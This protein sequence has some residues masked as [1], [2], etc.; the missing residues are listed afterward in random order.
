MRTF[1]VLW[2]IVTFYTIIMAS[3]IELKDIGTDMGLTG[4]ELR[5]F[6]TEQQTQ[7]RNDRQLEREKLAQEHDARAQEHEAAQEVIKMKLQ[8]HLHNDKAQH[9]AEH[10]K[11]PLQLQT[12]QAKIQIQVQ[13]EQ[14]K[15][16]ERD[17]EIKLQLME[18]EAELQTAT[19]HTGNT[20]QHNQSRHG[21]VP[22]APRLPP[23]EDKDDMDAYLQRFERYAHA[24]KWKEEEWAMHLGA[25]LKGKALEVYSR[26]TPELALDYD[27]LKKALLKRFDLTEEGFRKRFETS[28][29][30]QGETFIQFAIRLGNYM[31]R[32]IEL[33]STEKS[34]EGIVDLFIRTQLLQ[35]CGRDLLLFLKERVPKS[36]DEMATLA[37][38]FCD[39]RGRDY[40][41]FSHRTDRRD[42]RNFTPS[43]KDRTDSSTTSSNK[44]SWN[45]N[46]SYK[47]PASQPAASRSYN[48]PQRPDKRCFL[49]NRTGHF[50]S[51][52]R[53]LQAAQKAAAVSLAE[54]ENGA[55]SVGFVD[56]DAEG[57]Q[58]SKRPGSRRRG[59]NSQGGNTGWAGACVAYTPTTP[60]ITTAGSQTFDTVLTSACH[61][62]KMSDGM[63]TSQG[64][65]GD[66]TVTV[67]RD[68]GCSGV[69]VRR[70]LVMDDQLLG[71]NQNCMLADGT[72]VPVP[73][74]EI[75]VNTT[76]YIGI[77]EAWCMTNPLYDLILGNVKG[78]R[79]P[80]DLDPKWS[81][82]QA[83]QTRA[84]KAR[85]DLPYQPLKAPQAIDTPNEIKGAQQED[86][87]LNKLRQ[88]ADEG[89]VKDRVKGG[90]SKFI[91]K[92]G[93]L[94]REFSSPRVESGK[95]FTQLV[96]PETYRSKV[97]HLAHES[98]M[99]GH[100]GPKRTVSRVLTAFFWP[101]VQADGIRHCRSC[102]ICQRTFPKGRV[103]RVPLGQMPLI[104]T[105]FERIAV[106]LIGP[107]QPISSS[108][109]RYILTVVDYA[110]R[111]PEATA[112]PSIEA[113]RVAEA[114]VDI[115]CRV[116]IPREMLTDMGSQFTSG[117]MAETS[118]LLSLRQLTTTPYHPMCNGLVERFNGT[119]KQ[120]LRRV[121]AYQPRE[122][123]KYLSAALFV[124]REVPQESLGV[125]YLS[126]CTVAPSEDRCRS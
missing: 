43:S 22:K 90:T 52:C 99:S 13:T 68:T 36:I 104:E 71:R 35:S 11:L 65:V 111:Y 119:L 7:A 109:N 27:T 80:G 3:L 94:Y 82:A 107:L 98:L 2:I 9:D 60:V 34:Y 47:A 41:V 75:H 100:L 114:L 57:E 84:H 20:G 91:Y 37:D 59:R 125:H 25:L 4:E 73:V 55:K 92:K 101:G 115:F 95:L 29:P 89:T 67:L 112:L 64:R 70:S 19:P 31:T 30:E 28:R 16:K 88:S 118:R 103:G 54:A 78:V 62:P 76:Y 63:P 66:H 44:G 126:S 87:S 51:E 85:Q 61:N 120:M 8:I 5:N 21:S 81:L 102:D 77:V 110:T 93:L 124:Y 121:C 46:Q 72:V 122:W 23:F 123:D 39:A 108:G 24:H 97:L 6:I 17:M 15:A 26:L 117:L 38:Q 83:V 69:V 42:T 105:P 86:V 79:T 10:A 14:T 33:S 50:A 49:C 40:A 18:K 74:A 113:E 53:T 56:E 48:P 1:V 32:W 12:E 116:G 106:D 45:K 96:V 58:K